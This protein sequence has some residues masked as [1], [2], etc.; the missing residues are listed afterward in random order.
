MFLSGEGT[1]ELENIILCLQY[2]ALKLGL[3]YKIL[4]F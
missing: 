2:A 3:D 4:I 1:Y